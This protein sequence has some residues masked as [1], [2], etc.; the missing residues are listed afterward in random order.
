V[1]LEEVTK[2]LRKT[3]RYLTGLAP[4]STVVTAVAV[5]Q[6]DNRHDPGVKLGGT[7]TILDK[8]VS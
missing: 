1:V 8:L 2:D 6:F 4:N 7:G 3:N 5:E